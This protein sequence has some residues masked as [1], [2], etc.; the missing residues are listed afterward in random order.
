MNTGNWFVR[1]NEDVVMSYG[2][3]RSCVGMTAAAGFTSLTRRHNACENKHLGGP[4][5]SE[6]WSFSPVRGVVPLNRESCAHVI[7]SATRK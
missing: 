1:K 4:R 2:T 3:N 6:T 7:G 5:S